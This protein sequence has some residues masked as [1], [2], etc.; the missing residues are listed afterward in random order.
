MYVVKILK[1]IR[2]ILLVVFNADFRKQIPLILSFLCLVV[3][4][5]V[6]LQLLV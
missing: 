4:C 1:L 6:A 2:E 5:R 3:S